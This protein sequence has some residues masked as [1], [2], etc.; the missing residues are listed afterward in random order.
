MERRGGGKGREWEKEVL[1][2]GEGE[3][4]CVFL[5]NWTHPT[6]ADGIWISSACLDPPLTTGYGW[7]V[8]GSNAAGVG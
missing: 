6:Q 2:Q 7:E 8:E 4:V 3:D 1:R 5:L